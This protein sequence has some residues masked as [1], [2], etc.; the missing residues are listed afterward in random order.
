MTRARVATGVWKYVGALLAALVIAGGAWA[1]EVVTDKSEAAKQAEEATKLA[2]ETQN[3][4]ASLISVPFQNNF[5][6]GVGPDRVTQWILN[7][8]P[9]IPISLNEDWNL[10]TRTIMPIINQPSLAD[11]VRSAF[12]LGDINP[13]LFFSPAK[14]SKFIWGVG[15]TWTMPTAT[16]SMVGAGKWDAG[17]TVVALTMQGPWVIGVLANNQWSFA[18]WG[19]HSINGML[20]QPFINYNLDKGWYLTTSPIITAN[21][22]AEDSDVWTVPLGCG[23]GRVFRIGKQPV[24]VSLAAYDN[25][26]TPVNGP[27]WQLRFQVQLLFPK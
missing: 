23:V 6:F 5:N 10:I 27:D 1:D 22:N 14:P 21:W 4:V 20:V 13:S 7:V 11:G 25:V 15:P 24:N 16:D 9:V 17:P 18:G 19:P 3:P 26:H 2:K 8:Q 12:G